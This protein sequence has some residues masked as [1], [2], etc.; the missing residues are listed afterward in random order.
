MTTYDFDATLNAMIRCTS[1]SLGEEMIE[2]LNDLQRDYGAIKIRGPLHDEIASHIYK[3]S[4]TQLVDFMDDKYNEL[5]VMHNDV[6]VFY[7]DLI[8]DI[9]HVWC[10]DEIIAT[11]NTNMVFK[12]ICIMILVDATVDMKRLK[13][14]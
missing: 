3:M 12:I 14:M 9:L 7:S 11:V 1:G 8:Y 10:E 6:C 13:G 4:Y 5:C 2:Y